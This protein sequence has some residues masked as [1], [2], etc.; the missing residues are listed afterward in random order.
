MRRV[1]PKRA[2]YHPGMQTRVIYGSSVLPLVAILLCML[3]ATACPEGMTWSSAARAVLLTL[4]RWLVGGWVVWGLWAAWQRSKAG[5][6]VAA[7][8]LVGMGWPTVADAEGPGLRFIVSNVQAYSGDPEALEGA[9]EAMEPDVMLAMEK[10]VRKLKGMDRIAHNYDSDLPRPS[11]GAAVFC[12]KGLLCAAEVTQEIGPEGCSM[13]LTL[14]RVE[15]SVCVVGLHAPPPVPVCGRGLQP[16]AEHVASHLR[17]GRVERELGPCQP[18]DPVI[19]TGD[20]N[21]VPGSRAWRTLVNTGLDDALAWN[22]VWAASWP[23]GGG[24]PRLPF[25]RLDQVL[26][27]KVKIG[28]VDLVDLPGADHRALA[29]RLSSAG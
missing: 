3:L 28:R 24:W 2:G 9:I 4:P 26:T 12:R 29:F 27:G 20:L 13:P 8:A 16:Y 6:P 22:G 23:A 10:R 5:L 11:H 19:V 21:Q 14:V 25:F 1:Q 7:L 18:E 17:A 15:A